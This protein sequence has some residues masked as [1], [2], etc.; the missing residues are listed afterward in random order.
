MA[1]TQ[2]VLALACIT[3]FTMGTSG[4]AS[5]LEERFDAMEAEISGLKSKISGLEKELQSSDPAT[6]FDCYLTENWDTD[7]IIQFNGCA[8]KFRKIDSLHEENIE[9]CVCKKI[10][11]V[12]I[13]S[14]YLSIDH[15]FFLEFCF[16]HAQIQSHR[17]QIT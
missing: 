17:L 6:V 1:Y 14:E 16:I 10:L 5:T 13:F 11:T 3:A 7:G 9:F 12:G 15:T 8:G 2:V 4:D